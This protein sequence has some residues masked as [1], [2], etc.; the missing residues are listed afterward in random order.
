MASALG[1]SLWK[2]FSQWPP[3]LFYFST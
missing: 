2:G 3:A 1:C